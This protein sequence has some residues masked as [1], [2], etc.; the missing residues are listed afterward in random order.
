MKPVRQGLRPAAKGKLL[1][2]LTG[3]D[4]CTRSL[5]RLRV[6]DPDGFDRHLSDEL[7]LNLFQAVA[8]R[9]DGLATTLFRPTGEF[10]LDVEI[11]IESD[12]QQQVTVY[13]DGF[14]V[15]WRRTVALP[16]LQMLTAAFG[17]RALP[18]PD[19]RSSWIIDHD[20]ATLW[21]SGTGLAPDD[22]DG[23]ARE[24]EVAALDAWESL[25]ELERYALAGPS[26]SS[27]G[28]PGSAEGM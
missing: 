4:D 7:R 8:G 3:I 15:A 11:A 17:E 1:Q 19:E 27:R 2:C 10:D 23:I 25:A 20:G 26:G 14:R 5:V 21:A 18:T 22:Q 16:T 28:A 24:V 13:F 6:A 12:G 9:Q